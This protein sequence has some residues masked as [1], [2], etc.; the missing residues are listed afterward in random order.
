M[1]NW[2][3]Q[4]RLDMTQWS[5]DLPDFLGE[6]ETGIYNGLLKPKRRAEWL[7]GRWT[8]K[9]L[10]Q[11]MLYRDTG[12]RLALRD[13]VIQNRPDGS[14]YA[15]CLD[16]PEKINKNLA[17]TISHRGEKA[18]CAAVYTIP[19]IT[20]VIGAD[21]E[22]IEKRSDGFATSYFTEEELADIVQTGEAERATWVSAIWSAKEAALKVVRTGLR[23]DTR[24][25]SCRLSKRED[26]QGGWQRFETR[27]NEEYF[28]FAFPGEAFFLP[29]LQGWWRID[30]NDVL[31]LAFSGDLPDWPIQASVNEARQSERVNYVQEHGR[32][33]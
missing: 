19:G 33:Y 16:G 26:A 17:L 22:R 5:S 21:I 28:R 13:L 32:L 14:P 2:L 24:A 20:S 27:W 11:G 9:R 30:G 4:S 8:A 31:S 3:V 6:T 1:I 7:L 10:L 25:V 23:V 18:L 29:Q 12:Q 15:T